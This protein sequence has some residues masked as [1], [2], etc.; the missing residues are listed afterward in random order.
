ME[1]I[2]LRISIKETDQLIEDY[3]NQGV[4]FDAIA[5]ALNINR[6]Q[7]EEIDDSNLENTIDFLR[8][9]WK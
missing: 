1:T 9:Y 2:T 6:N 7:I 4:F 5:Q 3:R 8:D